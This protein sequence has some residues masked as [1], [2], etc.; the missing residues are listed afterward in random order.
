MP[1]IVRFHETGDAGVLKL[2]ELPAGEPGPG[3]VRLKVAAIGLNR[4]EV[5][6]RQGL[7]L[8]AP[9][10]P[11]R[12]GYE[13]AGVVEAV[14]SDVAEVK[15]GDRVSTIPS[16]SMRQYGV[17]GES[18][19][20]PAYA[21]APYPDTLSVEEG[22]AIWM[23]YLTAYGALMTYGKMT[24]EHAVLITAASSSV[25]LAAIQ[26]AKSIGALTVATTR[27]ADKKSFLLEAG[28][29][30]VI[31]TDEEDMA[32]QMK[33]LSSGKGA[34]LIFDPVAGPFLEKLARAAAPGA[35]L[36]EYGALSL[37]ETPYPLFE[38]LGKGLCIRGYTL[39]EIVKQ[40]ELLAAG[41]QFIDDGLRSGA[42]QPVID[43]T[44]TLEKIADAHRY[45]ESNQQ[46]GKI[47]VTV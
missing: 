17:Y 5:L 18:A 3:E 20:V 44:F 7:Y 46:K 21:V 6:F 23:Q 35:T 11:S 38:A 45:M 24:K 2:E 26:M 9:E 31:V 13:A 40:P 27:G 29:D 41:K 43:S 34:D 32:E 25:G 37:A 36:I 4:A 42:L 10:L 8:E 22:A 39:F 30:H 14:G 28:A 12:I 33:A 47:V 15:V 1:K 19:I 16:F